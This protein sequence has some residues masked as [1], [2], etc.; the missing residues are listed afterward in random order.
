MTSTNEALYSRKASGSIDEVIA[1]L[2]SAVSERKY[3][4]LG[5]INLR[6]KMNAK[7]VPF[8]AECRVFEVCNPQIAKGVL[9]TEMSISTVLPCRISVFE[10]DGGLEVAMLRP[11]T[12]LASFQRPDLAEHAGTVEDDMIAI[13]DAAAGN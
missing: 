3:G 2:E 11:S 7:G 4:L 6:E 9:E 5:S 1:R 12:L 13:I 10:R 8:D